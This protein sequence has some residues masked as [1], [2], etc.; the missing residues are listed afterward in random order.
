MFKKEK[1]RINSLERKVLLL[2]ATV[3]NLEQSNG[4]AV[5]VNKRFTYNDD[6]KSDMFCNDYISNKEAIK[7]I[8]DHLDLILE[9][10]DKIKRLVKR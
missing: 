5:L 9:V 10:P 4:Y 6:K 7:L 3:K 2:E 8:L 1:E